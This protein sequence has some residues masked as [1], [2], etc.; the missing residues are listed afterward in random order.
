MSIRTKIT[1]ALVTV[2]VL[3]LTLVSLLAYLAARN[4]VEH[5]VRNHLETVASI[6]KG[7]V[8]NIIQNDRARLA[9]LQSRTMLREDLQA[10]EQTGDPKYLSSFNKVLQDAMGAIPSFNGIQLYD[11]IGDLVAS[12]GSQGPT[13]LPPGLLERARGEAVVDV[14]FLDP[15]GE[16][17][18]YLA[19]PLGIDGEFVGTVVVEDGAEDYLALVSDYS[20]LGKT[21]ETVLGF[22]N[23]KGQAV[24]LTPLRFDRDAALTRII[25]S[26]RENVAITA[27]LAGSEG[28]RS[29]AVDYRGV[30]VVSSTRYLEEPGWG[31]VVKQDAGEAF[32]PANRLGLF[33]A[34]CIAVTALLALGLSLLVGRRVARPI[35][36]LTGVAGDIEAGDLS[37]R[38]EVR[39]SDE[40]GRLAA[41]FNAMTDEL[42]ESRGELEVRVEERTAELKAANEELDD[43][44]RTVSHDLRTLLVAINL[45]SELLR[46][47]LV[48]G[49]NIELADEYLDPMDRKLRDSFTL[50]RDLLAVA[51]A[52]RV[53]DSVADVDVGEVVERVL[54]ALG[55]QMNARGARIEVEDDL[56]VI[57]ANETQVYQVFLNLLTN[58]V[59]HN[60]APQPTAVV[61]YLG[62]D[63]GGAH[64]YRVCDNG[65]GI[66]SEQLD[67]LFVPF[68]RGALG[69]HGVGLATVWKIV[70]T[71]RGDIRAYNDGG[72]C[73]ELT[74][75][76]LEL[77]NT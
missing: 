23:E 38:A 46:E 73:F 63:P 41:T 16:L 64:R 37:R 74:M 60:E 62:R 65:S 61:S 28:F 18:H 25:E 69:G 58:A 50:I 52:G 66:A 5:D 75:C 13:Q 17:G 57:R 22:E 48:D 3:P 36:V 27:A 47:E 53:P 40:I 8:E 72:A 29:S 43:Y 35:V 30:P 55:P 7:R 10:Y 1:I 51:R 11:S 6:Q 70:K 26:G 2:A 68:K 59:Q 31:L 15:A 67:E 56:G 34:G 39:S 14:F 44:A 20:G 9:L 12:A 42:V 71:Y 19:G 77:L 32:G 45:N 24:F 33:L 21:G 4:T 54:S 49:G 76:D